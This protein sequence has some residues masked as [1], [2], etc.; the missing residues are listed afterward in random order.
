MK[1]G[2]EL[3]REALREVEGCVCRDRQATYSDAEDNFAVIAEF[4]TTHLR[5]RGLIAPRARIESFDVAAMSGLIKSARAAH[6][7]RHRDNWIDAAGYAICGA[8]IIART[9]AEAVAAENAVIGDVPEREPAPI[10]TLADYSKLPPGVVADGLRCFVGDNPDVFPAAPSPIAPGHN[11]DRLTEAQVGVT[12]GWRL[13]APEEVRDRTPVEQADASRDQAA[14]SGAKDGWD[15]GYAGLMQCFTYRTKQPP[16]YFL[17]KLP[18]PQ[19]YAEALNAAV[20][21]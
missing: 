14:W 21:P 1:T 17:P 8:G 18:K 20:A 2:T 4:W 5:T 7:P 9:E 3:R 13:L 16:G 19:S 11:P 6:N 12:E 10:A 15:S